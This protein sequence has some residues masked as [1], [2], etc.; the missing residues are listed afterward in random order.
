MIYRLGQKYTNIV[1]FGLNE[2]I[3]KSHQNYLTF[4]RIFRRIQQVKF[5]KPYIWNQQVYGCWDS[6]SIARYIHIFLYQKTSLFHQLSQN[7]TP[8]FFL[9][10]S[11]VED[12]LFKPSHDFFK[13]SGW[14]KPT[15]ECNLFSPFLSLF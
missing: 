5:R 15:S 11:W 9:G 12:I 6:C 3:Q 13:N 1:V 14:K 8:D 2:D 4:K 10:F 7:M